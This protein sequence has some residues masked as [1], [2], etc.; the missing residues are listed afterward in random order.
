MANFNKA[1]KGAIPNPILAQKSDPLHM[2]QMVKNLKHKPITG[3]TDEE[4]LSRARNL[5]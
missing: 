5:R 1:T 4:L 3:V 2:L